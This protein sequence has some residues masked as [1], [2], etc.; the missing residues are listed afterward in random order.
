MDESKKNELNKALE[1]M[2]D[3]L[4]DEQKEKAKECKSMDELMLLAGSAGVEL[5]DE[6]LDCVAGGVDGIAMNT[7]YTAMCPYCKT[8]HK[9]L[10]YLGKEDIMVKNKKLTT[11]VYGCNIVNK[12][13]YFFDP[14]NKY[15][16]Q[17]GNKLTFDKPCL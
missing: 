12:K 16:D 14:L 5:P 4:T 3:S 17:Y 7:G 2:W 13:F 6:I 8:G 15:Y 11:D 9:G 1:S 10:S